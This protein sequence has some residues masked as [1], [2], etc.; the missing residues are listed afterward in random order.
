[1]QHDHKNDVSAC[2]FTA[3]DHE[4]DYDPAYIIE[5]DGC[6]TIHM[7]GNKNLIGRINYG[8]DFDGLFVK[9]S[10]IAHLVAHHSC[11]IVFS[12]SFATLIWDDVPLLDATFHFRL[13]E[14]EKD[15]LRQEIKSKNAKIAELYEMI[16]EK[17]ELIAR[18]RVGAAFRELVRDITSTP[19]N[20]LE[21]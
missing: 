13:E 15:D 3:V 2:V 21:N 5:F 20:Q 1:M 16:I 17:D 18:L 12:N 14:S 9:P 6:S 11:R 8:D 4:H 7:S 10:Q 19:I